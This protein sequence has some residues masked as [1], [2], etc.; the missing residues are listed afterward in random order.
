M[1]ET[2]LLWGLGLLAVSLL[3][4]VVEVFIPSAGVISLIAA[5]VAIAGVACLFRVST[6]WGLA[7]VLTLLI[8]GPIVFF[9]SI[10][11]LPSTPMG[12]RLLFGET[13]E[14]EP[15]LRDA[16]GVG[17]DHL[18]GVEGTALTDLRPIGT[19]RIEGEKYDALSETA[20]VRAGSRVRVTAVEGNQI[21]VRPLA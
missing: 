11:I 14:D 15:V 16:R 7:G 12:K 17:Y 13:G 8:L 2:L 20:L 21:K 18:M 3:L 9:F 1:S 10:S 19:V 4:V 6:A 5:V